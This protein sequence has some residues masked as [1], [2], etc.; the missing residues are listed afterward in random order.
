[1]VTAVVGLEMISCHMACCCY[2]CTLAHLLPLNLVL[3]D[4]LEGGPKM[5]VIVA[6]EMEMTSCRYLH[7]TLVCSILPLLEFKS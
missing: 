2:H 1:M 3:A 6:L 5:M 7:C 4:V